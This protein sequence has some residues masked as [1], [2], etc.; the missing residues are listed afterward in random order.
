MVLIL[1]AGLVG[2]CVNRLSP[3][4]HFT[5]HS[6][7]LSLLQLPPPPTQLSLSLSAGRQLISTLLARWLTL[8]AVAAL[9]KKVNKVQANSHR[10]MD[11]QLYESIDDFTGYIF[12]LIWIHLSVREGCYT[13]TA[14]P[15]W[16]GLG[17]SIKASPSQ[18][19]S[20]SPV[21]STLPG[22]GLWSHFPPAALPYSSSL[23][24]YSY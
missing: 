11:R 15:V 9:S 22:F 6:L 1:Y 21:K 23:C 13:N 2:A 3:S 17:H 18:D 24:I 12:H 7:N 10:W 20:L 16:K 8:T 4:I 14:A 5:S 19:L